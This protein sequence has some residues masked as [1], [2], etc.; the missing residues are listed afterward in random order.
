MYYHDWQNQLFKEKSFQ[1]ELESTF[2]K[3]KSFDHQ[4]VRK[5]RA[6]RTYYVPFQ[7]YGSTKYGISNVRKNTT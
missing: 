4:K 7:A 6:A 5:K 2:K 3:V 1:V